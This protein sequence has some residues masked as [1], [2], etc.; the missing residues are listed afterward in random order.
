MRLF[1]MV[2]IGLLMFSKSGVTAS[3][4][5]SGTPG[6]SPVPHHGPHHLFRD[7]QNDLIASTNADKNLQHKARLRK[8]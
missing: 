4:T 3:H 7:S 2:G 6:D 1:P 8:V 5:N